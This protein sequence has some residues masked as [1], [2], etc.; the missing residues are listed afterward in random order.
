MPEV[1]NLL[2]TAYGLCVAV[3]GDAG[4]LDAFAEWGSEIHEIDARTAS[5]R[6]DDAIGLECFDEV[7]IRRLFTDEVVNE[8]LRGVFGQLVFAVIHSRN[9]VEVAHHG[10]EFFLCFGVREDGLLA[11]VLHFGSAEFVALEVGSAL[12]AFVSRHLETISLRPSVESDEIDVL[13]A[14]SHFVP[15]SSVT[16]D[17]IGVTAD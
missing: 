15:R 10:P 14:D 2:R 11:D 1:G 16:H 12:V 5:S 9:G 7:F 17:C 8:E 4:L 3:V 6:R 13:F